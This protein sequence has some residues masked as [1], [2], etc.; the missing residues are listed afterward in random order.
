MENSMKSISQSIQ[1]LQKIRKVQS[2][3][4]APFIDLKMGVSLDPDVSLR[5]VSRLTTFQAQ[6]NVRST[7]AS[8]ALTLVLHR[9]HNMHITNRHLRG[10]GERNG[11]QRR[12]KVSF[13]MQVLELLWLAK[14]HISRWS[15]AKQWRNQACSFSH[16]QVTALIRQSVSRSVENF[17]NFISGIMVDLKTFFGLPILPRC[18][19]CHKVNLKLALG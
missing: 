7:P 5:F 3:K 1:P 8:S 10:S 6:N 17:Q 12:T 9:S 14:R 13:M 2:L 11:A 16:Y 4:H 15:N 19:T 18:D